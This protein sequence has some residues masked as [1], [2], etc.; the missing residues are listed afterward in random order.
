MVEHLPSKCQ[1]REKRRERVRV[2]AKGGERK[3]ERK[4]L[5]VATLRM[6][7]R[8]ISHAQEQKYISDNA[9]CHAVRT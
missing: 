7:L 5:L 9:C 4:I 6:K 3:R 8:G 2:G 1:P